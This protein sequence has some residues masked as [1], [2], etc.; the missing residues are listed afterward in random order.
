MQPWAIAL[1]VVGA[2]LLVVGIYWIATRNKLVALK[3]ELDE[4]FSAMDVSM[5]KR[6]DL[7][8]NLVETVK[9]YAKHEKSTLE[10]VISARNLAM[11]A[12][13]PEAK[14]KA[15]QNLTGTLKTLFALSENY[16]ELQA[17]TN[18]L[19]L[20]TQLKAIETEIANSRRY[21]NALVTKYNKA[22][23][24]FPSNIVAKSMK[25]KPASMFQLDNIEERKNVKVE[26]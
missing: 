20:Q 22:V 1:I 23:Q 6:Y 24:F 15:E 11:T 3:I 5:K 19:D 4:G 13:D 17:N 18:F 21:Y 16:P 8:P 9:G 12:T 7:I 2:V 14:N 10:A 26:F 25:Y